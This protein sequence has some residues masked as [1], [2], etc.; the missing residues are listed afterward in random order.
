MVLIRLL[1]VMLVLI[2]PAEAVGPTCDQATNLACEATEKF[3]RA[4]ITRANF[5]GL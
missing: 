3:F 5:G 4:V 1:I 2:A